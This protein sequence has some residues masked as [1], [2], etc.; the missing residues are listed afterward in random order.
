MVPHA[1]WCSKVTEQIKLVSEYALKHH[2]SESAIY[3]LPQPVSLDSTSLIYF[4]LTYD[5]NLLHPNDLSKNDSSSGDIFRRR[6][7]EHN[8]AT[9]VIVE[10][11]SKF[12]QI[13]SK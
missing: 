6:S 13:I 4:R 12:P 7:R 9:D 5:N 1:C 10:M 11:T 2:D 8:K 3:S